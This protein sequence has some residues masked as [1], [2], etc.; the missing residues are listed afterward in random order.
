MSNELMR[1]VVRRMVDAEHRLAALEAQEVGRVL[2]ASGY[3][4]R[5]SDL[6]ATTSFADYLTTT[7][8]VP[9]GRI[10]VWA[11]VPYYVTGAA[12]YDFEAKLFVDGTERHFVS[13]TLLA[14]YQ[15]DEL[16]LIWTGALAAGAR[17][18]KVQI[19]KSNATPDVSALAKGRLMYLHFR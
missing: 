18:I 16:T 2:A 14:Q 12:G 5:G 10:A 1:E 15:Q 17:N 11:V 13:A 19:R 7:P 8:T 9:A 4:T 6:V 3:I